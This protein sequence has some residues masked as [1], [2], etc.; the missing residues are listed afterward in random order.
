MGL[1][2]EPTHDMMLLKWQP[3]QGAANYNIQYRR[4]DFDSNV[5][6]DKPA[7]AANSLINDIAKGH[8]YVFR[9]GSVCEDGNV[10]YSTEKT[11]FMPLQDEE[12]IK[13]C[14]NL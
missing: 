14:M 3:A 2:A 7:D 9:V 6:H 13:N 1:T 8:S 12:Q 4:E 5:W 10:V 11:A